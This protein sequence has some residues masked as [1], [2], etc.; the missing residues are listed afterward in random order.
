M[1]QR[2]CEDVKLPR[3]PLLRRRIIPG[4]GSGSAAAVTGSDATPVLGQGGISMTHLPTVKAVSA[5]FSGLNANTLKLLAVLAMISQHI[6]CLFLPDD[7]GVYFLMYQVGRITAPIM[8]FFIAEGFYHTSNLRKYMMRLLILALLSHVPHALAFGFSPLVFWRVTSVMWCHL[9]GLIALT[10]VKKT[11]IHWLWKLLWVGLC[12]IASYPGNFNCA[13]VLWILT[14]GIFRDQSVKKW[15]AFTAV[16]FLY[17]AEYWVVD[18]DGEP[19]SRL[20]ILLTI[21]LL[22]LYN[23]QLGRKSKVLQWGYYFIY[24]VHFLILYAVKCLLGVL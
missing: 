22:M 5:H 4:M 17:F 11:Q 13:V 20:L 12:C 23:H 7:T 6:A 10:V 15:L 19:W 8:C 2:H 14:F 21:P 3:V 1:K 18:S 24:P 9:L 16:T